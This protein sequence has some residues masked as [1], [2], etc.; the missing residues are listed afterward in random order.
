MHPSYKDAPNNQ[1][2]CVDMKSF[3][4]SIELVKRGIHPL[5]GYLAVIGDKNQKGSVILAASDALKSKY[6]IKTA[7]RLYDIPKD[8]EI[9][10]AE[11]NMQLY[12]NLSVKIAQMFKSILPLEAVHIYSVDEAWLKLDNYK[13]SDFLKTAFNLKQKIWNNYKLP[14]SMG[15]GPNMFMAKVAMDNEGKEKGLCRWSYDDVPEK[16][17]PL[18]LSD[19]WGIGNKTE[20]KLNNIGVYQLGDLANLPLDYLEN[21]FGIMGN[22]L[23][24]HAWGIDY[25]KLEGHYNDLKK[26]IGKGI[27]LYNDYSSVEEIKT[28]IFNLSEEIGKR[29]RE[30]NLKGKT[31][32]LSLKYS[33][34]ES[35]KGFSRQLSLEKEIDLSIEIYKTAE[36]IF[37]NYYSGEKVR[38]ITLYLSNL[39]ETNYLQLNLFK[40]TLGK[41]KINNIRNELS[42]KFGY[43][44]IYYAHNLKKGNIKNRIENTIGGHKK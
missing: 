12:L 36:K 38:K 37:N 5:K 1:I 40:N 18:K 34:S 26:A 25:S 21:K 11:A 31:V 30:D 39:I 23:Y 17:W 16:L 42:Q 15:I 8:K 28:V 20:K 2:L 32:S 7:D 14:C 6:G 3:Y 13:S 35:K 33:Y 29:L 9:I 27:T 4:A 19:C 41:A 10:L 43:D 24:Y 22:Q 44:P